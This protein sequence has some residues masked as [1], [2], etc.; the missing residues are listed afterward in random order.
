MQNLQ[1]NTD[2][3]G[4]DGMLSLWQKMQSEGAAFFVDGKA[5]SASDAALSAVREEGVYMTDYVFGETGK[6]EQVRLDRVNPE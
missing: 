6:V 3:S 2:H 5:V 4:E 1:D